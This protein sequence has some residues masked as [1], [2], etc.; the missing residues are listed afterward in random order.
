[1]TDSSQPQA[2]AIDTR[3]VLEQ[4][5]RR[6][7]Q[8]AEFLYGEIASRLLDR[9][10]VI[11]LSPTDIL[12]AGCGTGLRTQALRER[13]PQANL[14]SLDHSAR[15]L[16]Q[17]QHRHHQALPGRWLARWR[18]HGKHE[19]RCADLAQTGLPAQSLDL[20]WS[21]LAIHWHPRPH[22]VLREWSRILRSGGLAFFSSLGPATGIELRQALSLANLSTATLPLV[23]MHDLG[24][25]MVQHGFADPVMDQETISLTYRDAATLLRDAHALG[26][27]PN[28]QRRAGL[29]GRH[30]R[31][32]LIQALEAGRKP[33]GELT[34]TI[35]IAYGH[36]WR[37]S[38]SRRQ[39][40]TAI[41]LD[42]IGHR[43]SKPS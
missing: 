30:W 12:D 34:M 9:L 11:R 21:N 3:H 43:S 24:D 17:L 15:R 14:V 27:N 7:D 41:R 40:E 23:D 38:V 28:P 37:G 8:S 26:G 13:Y 1:M 32:R 25:L 4:F 39:G 35:E 36:A 6:D 22:D 20:V 33:S 42:A 16:A 10:R 18:K 19:T 2:L 31:D 5:E 29:A